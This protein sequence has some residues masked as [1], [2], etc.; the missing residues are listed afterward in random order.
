MK[1]GFSVPRKVA[2]KMALSMYEGEP[3]RVCGE[4]ITDATKAVYAGYS[5]DNKSRSAHKSC[6]Q[7]NLPK[8]SWAYPQ[9]AS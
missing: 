3:C 4:N 7:K 5:A 2:E 8:S 9:D 6:W 1:L